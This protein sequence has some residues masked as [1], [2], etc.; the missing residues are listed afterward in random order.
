MGEIRRKPLILV[1]GI[2][3]DVFDTFYGD[4][5]YIRPEDMTLWQCVNEPVE[6]VKALNGHKTPQ[7]AG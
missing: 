3:R 7:T 2:W 5:A 4:G 6:I 1:G